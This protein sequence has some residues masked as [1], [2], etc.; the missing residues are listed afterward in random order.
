[1]KARQGACQAADAAK[2]RRL[3]ADR[4]QV[5]VL[6][7]GEE[8]AGVERFEAGEL[9]AL[10]APTSGQGSKPSRGDV[11]ASKDQRAQRRQSRQVLAGAVLKRDSKEVDALQPAVAE[12]AKEGA[13]DLGCV[14]QRDASER[15]A[16]LGH[17]ELSIGHASPIHTRQVR[18]SKAHPEVRQSLCQLSQGHRVAIRPLGPLALRKPS[19]RW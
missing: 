13:R 9:E 1:M 17:R 3:E 10:E 12:L 18:I 6:R 2:T 19:Q 7:E 5:L 8:R 4:V 16:Q 15:A 11:A 14:E